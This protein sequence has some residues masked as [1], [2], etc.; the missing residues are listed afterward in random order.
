MDQKGSKVEEAKN[1]ISKFAPMIL[2]RRQK[3]LLPHTAYMA[4][5]KIRF[6]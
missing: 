5:L 2:D 1:V 3:S 6:R 4:S